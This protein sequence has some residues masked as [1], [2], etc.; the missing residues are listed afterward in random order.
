M[1]APPSPVCYALVGAQRVPHGKEVRA[2]QWLIGLAL[3][4]GAGYL[5]GNVMRA[6]NVGGMLKK[7]GLGGS[8]SERPGGSAGG[9]APRGL[10]LDEQLARAA[11]AGLQ[12]A[13]LADA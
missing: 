8:G 4:V 6:D 11:R 7:I 3:G 10:L 5:F 2:V 1:T 12:Q 9:K 13:G